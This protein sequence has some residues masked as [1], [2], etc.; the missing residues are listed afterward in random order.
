[1]P[2]SLS[3]IRA[4]SGYAKSNQS[5]RGGKRRRV[6]RSTRRGAGRLLK[7]T[8]RWRVFGGCCCAVFT[9]RRRSAP[10]LTCGR[11][12]V[13]TMT[14]LD[15]TTTGKNPGVTGTTTER[16]REGET[17]TGEPGLASAAAKA[18]ENRERE[19]ESGESWGFKTP[20]HERTGKGEKGSRW[21]HQR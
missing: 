15:E 18:V 2:A 19:A 6:R 10:E 1:M 17:A 9:K 4:G 20:R 11:E 3:V 13:V 8:E 12:R 7:R 21:R 5:T 16:P 14:P